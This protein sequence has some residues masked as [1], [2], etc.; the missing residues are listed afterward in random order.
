M[1]DAEAIRSSKDKSGVANRTNFN[2]SRHPRHVV[3]TMHKLMNIYRL[4][5][6]RKHMISLVKA[7]YEK[8]EYAEI[9]RRSEELDPLDANIWNGS[10]SN[11]P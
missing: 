7:G 2:I 10:C 4:R 8:N 3:W 5:H 11:C 6:R 1:L 9:Y